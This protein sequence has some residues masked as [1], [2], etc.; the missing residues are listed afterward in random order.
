MLDPNANAKAITRLLWMIFDRGVGRQRVAALINAYGQKCYAEGKKDSAVKDS[1][2]AAG[3]SGSEPT[4]KA[5][6]VSAT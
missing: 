6:A 2:S 1:R 4:Q 3:L 5:D